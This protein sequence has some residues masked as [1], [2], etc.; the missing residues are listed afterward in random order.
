MRVP[1][2]KYYYMTEHRNLPAIDR[3]SIVTAMVLLTYSVTAFVQ[4]P[5][6]ALELQL[7]GFLFVVKL[8]IFTVVSGLVALLA[9]AGCEWVL[10]GHPHLG[11][12]RHW[13]HWILPALTSMTIGVPLNSL[14]VGPAWWV[15]FGMG[16]ILLL[17]V[18]IA[19]Y[20]SVDPEDHNYQLACMVLTVVFMSLFLILAIAVRGAELRLYA[21]LSTLVPASALLSARIIH[22]RLAGRWHLA[23]V[24]AISLIL[25]QAAIGLFYLP[26]KPIQ[27]GL[28]LLAVLYG[29]TSL[30]GNAEE[31]QTARRLWLEPAAMFAV[32]FIFSFI[33]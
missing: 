19:E 25:G 6:R 11:D 3:L 22:L 12:Q 23:W 21:V 28:L 17:G 7:P 26:V 30:A 15:I 32:F 1:S 4:I 16:G 8:G 9:A 10:A 2:V 29:L 18:L 13:Y 14:E 31:E 27:F 24:G 20:I 33:L 5:E